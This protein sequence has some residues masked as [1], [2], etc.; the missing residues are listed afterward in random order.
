MWSQKK[1][2]IPTAGLHLQSCKLPTITNTHPQKKT[3]RLGNRNHI[4]NKIIDC[5]SAYGFFLDFLVWDGFLTSLASVW[6]FFA[7]SVDLRFLDKS[8]INLS[9]KQL[10]AIGYDFPNVEAPPTPYKKRLEHYINWKP[11]PGI[12]HLASRVW[13]SMFRCFFPDMVATHGCRSIQKKP[14]TFWGKQS[15]QSDDKPL[16]RIR[17]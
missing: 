14:F 6:F 9:Y 3:T 15:S 1:V 11:F 4:W 16:A 12:L 2:G 13:K 17:T 8:S 7:S 5:W 10:K